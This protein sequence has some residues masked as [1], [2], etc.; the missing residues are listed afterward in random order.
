MRRLIGR[1]DWLM[2]VERLGRDIPMLSGLWSW[3]LCRYPR[4]SF[5]AYI[6]RSL[7]DTGSLYWWSLSFV[8]TD[9]IRDGVLYMVSTYIPRGD[10][11]TDT[12]IQTKVT[13]TVLQ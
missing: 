13:I 10:L 11:G 9:R 2:M 12:T 8:R 4:M 7:F 3:W 6:S 5:L 1:I